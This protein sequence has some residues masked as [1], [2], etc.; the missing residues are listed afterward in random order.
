MDDENDKNNNINNTNKS[1]TENT[2][3]NVKPRE[4]DVLFGRGGATLRHPGNQ[5]YRYLVNLN[6]KL[7]EASP[8]SIKRLVSW[9]IITAIRHQGGRLLKIDDNGTWF[10]MGDTEAISKT[11]Q[12]IR[13][14]RKGTTDC[15]TNNDGRSHLDAIL[16]DSDDNDDDDEDVE[17]VAVP[18]A[19]G[20]N[21]AVIPTLAHLFPVNTTTSKS[22]AKAPSL[23]Q[24]PGVLIDDDSGF[25]SNS[26]SQLHLQSMITQLNTASQLNTKTHSSRKQLPLLTAASS[27]NESNDSTC[28]T[29]ATSSAILESKINA[30]R[31]SIPSVSYPQMSSLFSFA[32]LLYHPLIG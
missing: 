29:A 21:K 13:D 4:T 8:V 7:Y 9:S 5:T 3:E 1:S 19:A 27:H 32:I 2:T 16:I 30:N 15:D 28:S 23:P 20:T 25:A 6:R 12:A 18:A 10:Y 14:L 31:H 17:A 24:E 22:S 26:A 11:S